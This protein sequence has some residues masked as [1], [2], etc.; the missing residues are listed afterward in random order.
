MLRDNCKIIL[1]STVYSL[2]STVI[3][4]LC[5]FIFT[6]ASHCWAQEGFV[7]DSKGRRNPFIALVTP[8]GRILNLDR[9]QTSKKEL[10][11]EGIIYDED[12]RSFAIVNGLVIEVGDEVNEYKVLKIEDNKVT[13]LK[14]DNEIVEFI[15]KKEGR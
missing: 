14:E 13:F 3:L 15:L 6:V 12:G 7:Y 1:Q 2:Q 5:L 10:I 11:I 4:L 8:D 9:K